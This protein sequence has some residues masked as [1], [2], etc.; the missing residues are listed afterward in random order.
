MRV[1]I[2]ASNYLK[3]D[4]DIKKGTEFFVYILINNLVKNVK[5]KNLLLTAFCSEN[6]ILPVKIENFNFNSTICDKSVSSE[7]HIIFKNVELKF[8]VSI[9]TGRLEFPEQ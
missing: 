1:A 6:S 5:D 8:S 2:V 4:Q 3:I 9:F 7:K